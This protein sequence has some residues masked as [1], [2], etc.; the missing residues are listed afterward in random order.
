MRRFLAR[1]TNLLRRD[2][3]GREML[4]EIES[5]LALIAEDLETSGNCA[6][7]CQTSGEADVWR[8]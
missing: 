1:S 2:H 4:R 8:S 7:R 3:A 5:H 6:R